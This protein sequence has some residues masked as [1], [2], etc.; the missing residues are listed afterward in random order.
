MKRIY[1]KPAILS[2]PSPKIPYEDG[3]YVY[4]LR[5]CDESLYCGWTTNLRKRFYDHVMKNGAKYTKAHRPL[6]L[7]YFESCEDAA[8]ARKR[9]YAIKQL[10]R[11]EKL[12]LRNIKKE[13]VTNKK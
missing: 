12:A 5:C 4:L 3:F 9:E 7:Y 13:A 6:E 2:V 8:S 10:S 1:K 11:R